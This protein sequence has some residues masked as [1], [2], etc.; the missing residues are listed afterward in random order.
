MART[1]PSSA[2]DQA[3]LP[4]H[5]GSAESRGLR[6]SRRVL[7]PLFPSQTPSRAFPR[8]LSISCH[9]PAATGPPRFPACGAKSKGRGVTGATRPGCR[10]GEPSPQPARPA[11]EMRLP[12]TRPTSSSSSLRSGTAGL[13][14]RGAAEASR[15]CS[16]CPSSPSPNPHHAVLL[17][18]PSPWG[19]PA[20]TLRAA[21]LPPAAP[22]RLAPSP[23]ELRALGKL[24]SHPGNVRVFSAI[25]NS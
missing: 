17:L 9:L 5:R 19:P 4:R 25:F 6:R 11:G 13:E 23:G 2:S 15:G 8:V 12:Q 24:L 18:G 16:P 1:A 10:E 3:R 22:T 7:A 21:P 14:A 20:L